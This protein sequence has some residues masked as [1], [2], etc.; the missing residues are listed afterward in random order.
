MATDR[1][2]SESALRQVQIAVFAKAPVPGLVKTRLIPALDAAAAARL[3]RQMTRATLAGA[4]QA[5][6]GPVT[7]WCAPDTQQRFFRALHKTTGVH[8][9]PQPEGDLGQRMLSAFEWHCR[10][11][12]LLLVGTDCPALQPSHLRAAAKALLAGADA[13]F[14]PTEDG[15]YALIGLHQAQPCLFTNMPWSTA[16]VMQET[17]TR[18]S[19]GGLR[20]CELETLWDVDLPSDLPRLYALEQHRG[21]RSETRF[22]HPARTQWP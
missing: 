5:E 22:N 6:L 20:L 7:L 10:H 4:L 14:H 3:Q 18:A 15:G 19:S 17:R 1:D 9:R 11:S 21:E 8:C 13:V 2:A 12:P 16:E